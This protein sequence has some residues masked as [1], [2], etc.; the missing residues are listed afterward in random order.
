MM[1]QDDYEDYLVNKA[2]ELLNEEIDTDLEN[3]PEKPQMRDKRNSMDERAEKESTS[4]IPIVWDPHEVEHLANN[5]KKM[6]NKELK[7]FLQKD[8]EI[9]K[10]FEKL[11]EWTGFSRWEERFMIQQ[12]QVKSAKAIAEELD[13]K[14]KEVELK[15]RT[16][17]LQPDIE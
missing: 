6:S 1:D 8:A 13:R 15:M 11:D 7:E 5:R 12:H 2:R 17:G 9:Q 16:M 14:E 3:E 4:K 10:E